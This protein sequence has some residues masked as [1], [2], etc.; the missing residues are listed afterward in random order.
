MVS[1]LVGETREGAAVCGGSGRPEGWAR[2]RAEGEDDDWVAFGHM[3]LRLVPG[4]GSILCARARARKS[5]TYHV[6][7]FNISVPV[8]KFVTF[9]YIHMY[10]LCFYEVFMYIHTQILQNLLLARNHSCRRRRK[11]LALL[12][13]ADDK[14]Y[15]SRCARRCSRSGNIGI[16]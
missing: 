14:D 2:L 4:C 7:M 6:Y 10:I 8:A 13:V 15:V 5:F 9:A 11:G 3:A 12:E 1:P 16:F